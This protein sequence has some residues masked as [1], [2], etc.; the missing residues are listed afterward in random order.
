MEIRLPGISLHPYYFNAGL[1]TKLTVPQIP[2]KLQDRN[3]HELVTTDLEF[4]PERPTS[5]V[6]FDVESC[7]SMRLRL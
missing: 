2:R 5:E 1:Q 3:L 4:L 7:H 6:H